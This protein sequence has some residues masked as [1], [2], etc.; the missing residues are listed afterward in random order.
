MHKLWQIKQVMQVKGKL[1]ID[2]V[3]V[4]GGSSS[5][6]I[7]I[8]LNSLMAWVADNEWSIESLVY[9][10]DSFGIEEEGVVEE[11]ELYGIVYPVLQVRLL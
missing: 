8:S 7:F 6:A 5:G 9:V 2:R 3:N 1:T 11:Y 4:F 10:D